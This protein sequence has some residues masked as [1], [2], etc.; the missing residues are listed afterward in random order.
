MIKCL[1]F[2]FFAG[3]MTSGVIFASNSLKPL[4]LLSGE[5]YLVIPALICA[6]PAETYSPHCSTVS[7]SSYL[8]GLTK[9]KMTFRFRQQH[10]FYFIFCSLYVMNREFIFVLPH[11]TSALPH[12]SQLFRKICPLLGH[13]VVLKVIFYKSKFRANE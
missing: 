7:S 1:H 4:S 3:S 10:F 13:A 5:G 8:F 2:I 6:L 9:G 11:I 12:K